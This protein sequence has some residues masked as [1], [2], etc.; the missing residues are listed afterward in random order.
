MSG[1][2]VNPELPLAERIKAAHALYGRMTGMALRLDPTRERMWFDL[3]KAGY[4]RAEL[5]AVISYLQREIRMRKRNAGAL[6]LSNLLQLDRFE[7]DLAMGR[8]K[9]RAPAETLPAAPV[10]VVEENR[11]SAEEVEAGKRA[12]L[13]ELRRIKDNL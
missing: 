2:P 3:F 11:L 13:D 1:D 12:A 5:V 10:A 8:M 4:G 9:L 6:K 7:E